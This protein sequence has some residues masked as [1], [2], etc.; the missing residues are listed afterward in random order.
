[1]KIR[2]SVVS[3]LFVTLHALSAEPLNI[4]K[5]EFS[6]FL[7]KTRIIYNQGD[8]SESLSAVNKQAYPVLLQAKI[9][10]VNKSDSVN[11]IVTPPIT[12]LDPGQQVSLRIIKNKNIDED[13]KES[14]SYLC[15]NTLPPEKKSGEK[16][17]KKIG[18]NLNV[19]VSTCEKI[20]YR[21][22]SL[23]GSPQT[24]GAKLLWQSA[25]GKIVIHN[26]TPFVM[27]IG[28]LRVNGKKIMLDNYISPQDSLT[29]N[30]SAEK[31]SVINWTVI[32]DYGGESAVF[33]KKLK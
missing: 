30:E 6:L 17:E 15:I 32:A 4:N 5:R 18:L 13:K 29:I 7:D 1:M 24:E 10:P 28:S 11:F 22:T 26:P 23:S 14:M 8:S 25:G 19:L 31:G 21:P 33:T 16:S 2:L 3:L 27:T 9:M 12:R 20:I